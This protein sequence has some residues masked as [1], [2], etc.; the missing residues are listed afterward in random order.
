VDRAEFGREEILQHFAHVF[1][2]AHLKSII[3]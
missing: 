3:A 2:C 1:D